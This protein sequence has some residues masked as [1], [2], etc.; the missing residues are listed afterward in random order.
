MPGSCGNFGGVQ[1]GPRETNGNFPPAKPHYRYPN[2]HVTQ[3]SHDNGKVASDDRALVRFLRAAIRKMAGPGQMQ[4]HGGEANVASSS[5]RS[6]T[7]PDEY[8]ASVRQGTYNLTVTE[9]GNFEA[10]LWRIDLPTL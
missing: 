6:F 4:S 1:A 8:A 7:E 2:P 5:V 3:W 10:K 9:P